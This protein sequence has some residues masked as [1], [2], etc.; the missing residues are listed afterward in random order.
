MSS[1]ARATCTRRKPAS[2][3]GLREASFRTASAGSVLLAFFVAVRIT[4]NPVSA[5]SGLSVAFATHRG[6]PGHQ[7]T[8]RL[9]DRPPFR[10]P[11]LSQI[12]DSVG[13]AKVLPLSAHSDLPRDCLRWI[14]VAARA[15][16]FVPPNAPAAR[17]RAC[18]AGAIPRMLSRMSCVCSPVA[19][20]WPPNSA[21]VPDIRQGGLIPVN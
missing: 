14:A 8:G 9:F 3:S 12:P 4:L 7:D 11:M 17:T 1:N 10:I 21:R 5:G 16:G 6:A 20:T 2:E 15:H 18:S 13:S 19:G